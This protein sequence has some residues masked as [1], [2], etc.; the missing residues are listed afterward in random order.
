MTPL[1]KFLWRGGG[2]NEMKDK[3]NF[4]LSV[5][6]QYSVLSGKHQRCVSH[7]IFDRKRCCIFKVFKRITTNFFLNST[8]LDSLW[9]KNRTNGY[10]TG[11]RERQLTRVWGLILSPSALSL[12]A[13]TQAGLNWMAGGPL[14]SQT[15]WEAKPLMHEAQELSHYTQPERPTVNND[16]TQDWTNA[17]GDDKQ[18]PVMWDDKLHVKPFWTIYFQ[19]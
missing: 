7:H 4:V 16:G 2:S 5:M 13:A 10:M 3:N 9:Y 6:R 15:L 17:I 12:Q 11:E 18:W 14:P 1:T 8:F 19:F